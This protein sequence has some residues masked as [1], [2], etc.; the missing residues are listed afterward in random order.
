RTK[1]FLQTTVEALSLVKGHDSSPQ[2]NQVHQPLE[3][4]FNGIEVFV[5]IGVVEFHRAQNGG[6]REIVQ[7][8]RPLVK[9]R[10]I[11]FIALQDEVLSLPQLE[12]AAK[13]FR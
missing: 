11:V 13:V 8:L 12:T 3:G 7:K 5:D 10:R 4:R 1:C 9:E 6:V 2:R